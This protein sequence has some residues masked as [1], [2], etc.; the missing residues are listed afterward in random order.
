M[1][2]SELDASRSLNRSQT[3]EQAV[4]NTNALQRSDSML[5]RFTNMNIDQRDEIQNKDEKRGMMRQKMLERLQSDAQKLDD[6]RRTDE[7]LEIQNWASKIELENREQ[8]NRAEYLKKLRQDKYDTQTE[9]MENATMLKGMDDARKLKY[10]QQSSKY[11]KDEIVTEQS[12][13]RKTLDAL[14]Q[15]SDS[16]GTLGGQ[17]ALTGWP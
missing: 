16:L 2:Q 15:A 6:S 12:Q 5:T 1:M 10:Q 9:F 13:K 7:E 17:Q 3:R 4:Y 11:K 8:M 14:S